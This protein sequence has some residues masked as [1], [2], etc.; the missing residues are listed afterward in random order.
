[1]CEI[2]KKTPPPCS[3]AKNQHISPDSTLLDWIH[4][5]SN[6]TIE[7]LCKLRRIL[8]Y[9]IGAPFVRGMEVGSGIIKKGFG[10]HFLAPKS[11]NRDK[12]QLF[13]RV[14]LQAWQFEV[15]DPK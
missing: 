8:N 1:M 2:E 5:A 3:L 4:R 7:G 14:L 12:E 15:L 11:T 10:G 6:R 9:S 13:C